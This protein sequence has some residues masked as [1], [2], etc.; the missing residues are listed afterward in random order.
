VRSSPYLAI[1]T[2]SSQS[3]ILFVST[4]RTPFVNGDLDLLSKNHRVSVRIGS[5]VRQ[6]VEVILG[7]FHSTSVFCWFASVY[8]ALAV[9]TAA[10]LGKKSVIVVGGVDMAKEPE[11]DYGLWLSRWRS[12]LVRAAVKRAYR[13]LV[14]DESLK[15]EVL[16][17]VRYA[18]ANIEVLPTGYDS[19]FWQPS[20]AKQP[21]VLTV[22]SVHT[23]GRFK[24]KGIDLLFETARKL[25]D[26]RFELVGVDTQVSRTYSIP[27]NVGLHPVLD[28]SSLVKQY[29]RARVYCQPS[30]R[31]GLSNTL[32]EAM[33]CAC[34][35]V[36]T[37]VGGSA[38]AVGE[39]GIIVRPGNPDELADGIKR[40][41][42]MPG[43]V[44]LDARER[45]IARYPKLRREER[46]TELMREV[47]E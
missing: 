29:Q 12:A 41:L 47:V 10:L 3:H 43:K 31:E 15:D 46:L 16:Q 33:L 20:E 11:Y 19:E 13:V 9:L 25:P 37:D 17:R 6:T 45:I 34:I 4:V 24:I 14:V 27:P 8:A 44:G 1:R 18:G 26:V 2:L 40:A 7:V 5:G 21:I 22:A 32:C 42:S 35:P 38:R 28:Q 23:E 36:A 39:N 30:R